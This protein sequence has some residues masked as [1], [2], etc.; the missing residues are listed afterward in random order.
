MAH[1][2]G[3]PEEKRKTMAHFYGTLEGS[4]KEA[5]CIG[6]RES[7]LVT[8]CA[9]WKGAVRC[10]AWDNNG[11]D[12]IRVERV[13]WRGMGPKQLLYDGPIGEE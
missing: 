1:F 5:T 4:R 11:V 3:T 10:E 7:G 8:Y 13:P 9:S 6:S 12:W 2:Y